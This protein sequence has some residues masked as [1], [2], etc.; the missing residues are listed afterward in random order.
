MRRP[1]GAAFWMSL[2][3]RD[4]GQAERLAAPPPFPEGVCFHAQQA[5]E[6]AVKAYLTHLGAQDIPRDH[7]LRRLL[8]LAP[9]GA[10]LPVD[11]NAV[12][13]L[14]SYASRARYETPWP[15]VRESEDALGMAREIVRQVARLLRPRGNRQA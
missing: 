14:T 8:A 5:G 12:D 1:K 10:A 13:A 3:R 6:K 7:N 4:L 9:R 15:S 11:W 2:A